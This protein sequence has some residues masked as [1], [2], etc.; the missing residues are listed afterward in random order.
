[1]GRPSAENSCCKR[2]NLS[3]TYN[4]DGIRTSK[5]A[6]GL[7][8]EYFIDGS[9]ILAQKTGNDVMWFLYDS[10]GTKI[11]FTYNGQNYYYLK[12]AQGDITGIVDKS[13]NTVVEYTYDAWVKV[14]NMTDS[15][16]DA[17]IGQKNPFLYRGYY[18]DSETGLYYLN[19]RYYNPQTG[20]FLNA[21][22]NCGVVGNIQSYNVFE[23][24]F[25]HPVNAIDPT[26]QSLLAIA[27]II[28]GCPSSS[29]HNNSS[30]SYSIDKDSPHPPVTGYKP[31]K[32]CNKRKGKVPAPKGRGDKGWPDKKGNVWVPDWD[33]DGGEGWRRHYT[34]GK[35]D[36]VYPDGK[37]RTH[38]FTWDFDF[39]VLT[40]FSDQV[41]EVTGLT[42]GALIVYLFI[43]EGSRIIPQRNLIP[44]I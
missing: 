12:N 27:G 6:N 31:P 39:Q 18:Y 30:I 1:M 37:V 14:L 13:C 42:G 7:T 29:A 19:S 8:T 4:D 43:F 17:H 2:K 34:N 26:G 5:T 40:S 16:G 20:R 22:G 33:M 15:S 3:Y 23:Y 36:H 28:V 21:D 32:N 44:V 9:T 11:G 10:D 24:G 38:K 25:N 35:H 41:S